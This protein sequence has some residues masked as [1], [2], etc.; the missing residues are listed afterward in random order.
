MVFEGP[1]SPQIQ[2]NKRK[3]PGEGVC[4]V[5]YVVEVVTKLGGKK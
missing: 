4:L 5:T 2:A 3:V 1:E